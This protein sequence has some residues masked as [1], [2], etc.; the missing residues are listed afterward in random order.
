[1]EFNTHLEKYPSTR[2]TTGRAHEKN[3]KTEYWRNIRDSKAAAD[4]WMELDP[5][6][7]AFKNGI[8]RINTQL[9][10]LTHIL[11]FNGFCLSTKRRKKNIN[12]LFRLFQQPKK[13]RELIYFVFI[14][15]WSSCSTQASATGLV[16]GGFACVCHSSFAHRSRDAMCGRLY[17]CVNA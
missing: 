15:R 12:F 9:K 1:M 11:C 4:G 14:F 3:N 13:K 17:D 5:K 10:P 7:T 6:E 2:E 16:L 8:R